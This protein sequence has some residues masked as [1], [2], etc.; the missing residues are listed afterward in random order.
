MKL[1]TAATQLEALGNP[2]RLR[3]YRALVRA[4]EQGLAV[5]HLQE[6]IG[7]AASTLSHHLHRL[8]ATGLVGQE[9]Q[10]TT[11]ICRANY[12]AMNGLLGFLSDECCADVRSPQTKDN[13]A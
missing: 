1:E 3:I 11:L 5:G 2:T 9:R 7:I 8:I 4:G 6:R 13:A 10:A 12:A